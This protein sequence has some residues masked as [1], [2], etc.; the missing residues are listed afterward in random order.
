MA[1][2]YEVTKGHVGAHA[3][4]LAPNVVDT[5]TFQVVGDEEIEVRSNGTAAIYFTLDGSDPAVKGDH[6][7][8][9]P[10]GVPAVRT[11]RRTKLSKQVVKLIS[12]GSPEYSVSKLGD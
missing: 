5:V 7:Y 9:L 4:T 8:E 10:T 12:A 6:C 2:Y 1:T 3:K 11:V